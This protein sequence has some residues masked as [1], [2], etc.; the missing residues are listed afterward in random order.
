MS[1]INYSKW[2][3]IEISDDEDDTHPN[4]DTASLFKWRHEARIQREQE[5]KEAKAKRLAESKLRQQKIDEAKKKLA[6]LDTDGSEGSVAQQSGLAAELTDLK[7]QEEEFAKKE[8][9]LERFEREHPKW[10]V[11]NISQDSTSRTIINKEKPKKQNLTEAEHLDEMNEFFKKNKKE[12]EYFGMLSDPEASM[13][14]LMEHHELVC[15]HLA[16]YLVVWCV[17][18]EVEEKAELVKRVARQ[19]IIVQFIMELAKSVKQDPR[20]CVPAFF[21]R[22]KSND[23]QYM[24]SFN[25]EYEAFLGRVKARAKA[26][27]EEAKAKVEAEEKQAR[28]G[29]GGL[30]PLEVLETLPPKIRE[31]FETQNTPLLQQSFAELPPE[32]AQYHLKR[33]ID[34]GLWV[35]GPQ[36]DSEG[37]DEFE[38]DDEGDGDEGAAEGDDSA[39]GAGA[40]P[41]ITEL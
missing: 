7:R 37:D 39:A 17:D 23:P 35:P 31:A 1:T 32:Q 8:A 4:V 21:M 2:D 24:A 30:D 22:F 18:L 13:K 33:A 38:A 19:T 9:E 41:R 5:E 6:E 34:S 12:I 11:D 14:Y 10:N 27:F 36:G 26:R 28:V 3:H 20:D 29:P 15:D 16:S 40:G 25:D